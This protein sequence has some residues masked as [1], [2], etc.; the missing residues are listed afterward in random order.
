MPNGDHLLNAVNM[1]DGN[2]L[3]HM[4]YS[5]LMHEAYR[6]VME[7]FYW[8][9]RLPPSDNSRWTRFVRGV[10]YG[11]WSI[12]G[13]AP[14]IGVRETRRIMGDYVLTERDCQAGLK[15]Q[16]H[17]DVIAITDHAVDVHGRK[18]RLYEV[19]HGAYGVPY[20]CLLPRGVENLYIASRAASFSHIAA[21]SCRLCRTMM[22]LGQAAGNAAAMAVREGVTTRQVHVPEL[23]ERLR[24][25]GVELET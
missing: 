3:L 1:I 2:A 9:Q 12:A 13:I 4:E 25:Q 7:H 23:R 5:E 15:N 22:T 14:R 19:P 11:T 6:R 18:G 8:L 17:D 10:G 16:K 20:R 21:S 24:R